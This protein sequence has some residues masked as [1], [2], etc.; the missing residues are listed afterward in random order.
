MIERTI[1]RPIG[2]ATGNAHCNV[3]SM[4]AHYADMMKRIV[5][6]WSLSAF[7]AICVSPTVA[8][9][10]TVLALDL[11]DLV[12]GA[13]RIAIVTAVTSETHYDELGRIVTDTT[14]R[15]DE[16]LFGDPSAGDHL[17][18]RTLGGAI[19]ELGMS[20]AGEAELALDQ[21]VLLFALQHREGF[22]RPLGMSQG[23]M[24]IDVRTGLIQPGGAD[25]TLVDRGSDGTLRP[26]PAALLEPTSLAS[27]LD[28][29]RALIS[30]VRHAE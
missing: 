7:F 22:L 9:A 3:K 5:A 19:G 28:R 10:T 8:S 30:E 6:G 29:V 23:V 2:V 17:V 18:V 13:D 12:A 4:N 24:P 20:I 14:V 25:L 16:S 1:L 11:R 26:A 21:R 27:T 15:V